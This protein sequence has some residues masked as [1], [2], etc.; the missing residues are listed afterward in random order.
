MACMKN[1]SKGA[2]RAGSLTVTIPNTL[3]LD[4]ARGANPMNT[5]TLILGMLLGVLLILNAIA[6]VIQSIS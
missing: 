5:L 4:F 3:T 6:S 1:R 2:R